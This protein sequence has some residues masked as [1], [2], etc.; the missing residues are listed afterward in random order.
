ENQF[1]II[2]ILELFLLQQKMQLTL[3]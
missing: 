2:L 3:C 1:Q